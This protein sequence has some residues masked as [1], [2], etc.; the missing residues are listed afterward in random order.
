MLALTNVA[1]VLGLPAK[2][3]AARSPFGLIA[4]IEHGLPLDALERVTRL[5][6]PGDS[7]FKYR[8]VPIC[9]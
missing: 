6:S 5:L 7:Q 9:W 3:G 2:E 4:R 8:L 1:D